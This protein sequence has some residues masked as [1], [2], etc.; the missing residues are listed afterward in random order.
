LTLYDGC[1]HKGQNRTPPGWELYDLKKD[2]QEVV[3]Q[4]DN[5][6][7]ASVVTDLKTRLAKLRQRVGDTGDDYPDV[8]AVVQDVWDYDATARKRAKQISN[9]YLAKRTH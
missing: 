2:P 9:D 6:D 7:Y 4:Y 3:N 1:D 5:P 8:E